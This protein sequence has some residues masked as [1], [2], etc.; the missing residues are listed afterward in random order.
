M[1]IGAIL[2]K[3]LRLGVDSFVPGDTLRNDIRGVSGYL[4]GPAAFKAVEGSFARPLVGSIPI[5]SRALQHFRLLSIAIGGES[6]G[7]NDRWTATE[8]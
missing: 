2:Y 5:H 4:V 8:K 3:P 1:W 6:P 7:R